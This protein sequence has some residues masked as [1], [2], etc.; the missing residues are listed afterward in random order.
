MIMVSSLSKAIGVGK[1]SF[2][3]AAQYDLSKRGLL[4]SHQT[5]EVRENMEPSNLVLSALSNLVYSLELAKRRVANIKVLSL[6]ES[7][8]LV[9]NTVKGGWG[10]QPSILVTS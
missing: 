8:Q 9:A 7:K 10:G 6:R 3:N 2:V 4:P 1:T 5:I